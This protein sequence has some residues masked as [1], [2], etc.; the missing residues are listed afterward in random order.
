MGARS[1]VF[2][3]FAGS[4]TGP[5]VPRYVMPA[6]R[7][8]DG[9]FDA[10]GRLYLATDGAIYVTR[11]DEPARIAREPGAV[12]GPSKEPGSVHKICFG[13]ARGTFVPRSAPIEL[14]ATD[15]P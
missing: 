4:G 5:R 13:P 14:D 3:L 15:I 8:V 6:G 9:T 10:D 2:V 11:D 12:R 7:T 1:G